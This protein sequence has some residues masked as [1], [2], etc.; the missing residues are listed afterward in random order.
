MGDAKK[1]NSTGFTLIELMVVITIIGI[2]A[3]IAIPMY[4]NSVVKAKEATLKE[5]LYQIRESIDKYYA[6]NNEY[7]ATLSGI[8]EKKY[9]RSIPADPFTGS[10]DTWV[11]VPP[12]GSSGVFDV[13]SGS[14]LV[15]AN[16]VAYSE[17]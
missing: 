3:G 17:W 13:H 10:S 11:E 7:P 16:G 2:L 14:N 9:I 8:V 15:G 12:Q 5:D 6:D 4:W 1:I